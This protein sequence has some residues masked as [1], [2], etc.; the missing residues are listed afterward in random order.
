MDM[1]PAAGGRP[2]LSGDLPHGTADYC[3]PNSRLCL[4][5]GYV[6]TANWRNGRSGLDLTQQHLLRLDN[7][8]L[9]ASGTSALTFRKRPRFDFPSGHRNS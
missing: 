9:S 8:F 2:R 4:H 7:E 1:A 6:R 5:L 3:H